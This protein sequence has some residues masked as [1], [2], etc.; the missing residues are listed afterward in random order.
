LRF[1]V[2]LWQ[3]SRKLLRQLGK[4]LDSRIATE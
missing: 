1:C 3:F 4:A 2:F